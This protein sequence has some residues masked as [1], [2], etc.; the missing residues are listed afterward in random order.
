M[1]LQ[2]KHLLLLSLFA[3]IIA[4][5][6]EL[7]PPDPQPGEADFTKTIAVGGNF[8]AGYQDGALNMDGQRLSLPALLARQFRLAGGGMFNQPL[9]PDN[10]GFGLNSKSWEIPFVTASHLGYRTDCEGV[11]S[12]GPVKNYI[13]VSSAGPYL[14]GV[15]GN[16]FQDLSVPFARIQ[17]YFNPAFGLSYSSGNPNPYYNRFA[18]DP[19]NST[20]Y[21]DAKA[22]GATFITMWTG[23]ED[24]YEYARYGGY[25]VTIASSSTFS[26]YLDSLLSGLTSN[27]AKGVIA[28]IPHLSSFPFY[29]LISPRGLE[30]TQNKADSLNQLTGGIFNFQEGE[31]GF[32]I[33][34]NNSSFGY[35]QMGMGE[36]V[37]LSV[38]TDSL[39][40]DYLGSFS[41]LPDRYAL[42]SSEV[43]TIE[44]AIDAY[45]SIIA[46][47]AAQYN[48]ALVDMNT[49]FKT[50][51]A[52]VMWNGVQLNAEF[53]S[54]GFFSLDGY[55]PNQ[56]GYSL[57]ANEFIRVINAKYGSTIPAVNCTE[58]SGIKFP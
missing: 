17:D 25:N 1:K 13:P 12:L 16:S 28:N 22:Q 54:G 27:G 55:H 57:I 19:G 58:C 5:T 43:Q 18:S 14:Q 10:T 24:I 37:L 33:A 21:F 3:G 9:M 52:G 53:V 11:T 30:L 34:D 51:K 31:N 2:A 46:Q 36:Y 49:Y 7:D 45:N 48:L 26:A 38:P 23:M 15:A 8:L 56:K 32:V 4:C 41:E 44:Q 50:V 39:K 42:D 20:L 6:P 47:K 40:C 35:R 29:T